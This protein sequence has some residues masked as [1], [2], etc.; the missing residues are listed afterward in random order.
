MALKTDTFI[1][2]KDWTKRKSGI[3]LEGKEVMVDCRLAPIADELKK[4][5]VDD[6]VDSIRLDQDSPLAEKI[7]ESLTTNETF[8]FRDH[9]PFEILRTKIMPEILEYRKNMKCFRLWC[10]ASSTGQE[11]YSIAMLLKHHF[12]HMDSWNVEI[13]ATDISDQMVKKA[14]L[15][16]YDQNEINRGLPAVLLAKY[17][18][19]DGVNFKL[20]EE[21]RK[22]VTF[23]T[24]NL[25][26]AYSLPPDLDLIFI[27]N[28]LIYFDAPTKKAILQRAIQSLRVGGFLFLG[29]AETLYGMDIPLESVIGEKTIYYRK[30]K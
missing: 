19:P 14:T 9:Y 4:G 25:T 6:L 22:K 11:P 29:S 23:K 20:K 7:L 27:R 28:V 8:W 12:P 17:F 24:L 21:I 13:L 18:D 15:G 30:A 1:F 2:L 26:H 3:L 16:K 10:G 5:S